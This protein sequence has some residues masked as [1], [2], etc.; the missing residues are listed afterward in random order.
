MRDAI[1]FAAQGGLVDAGGR[2]GD[3]A[4]TRMDLEA[5]L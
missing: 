5:L 2:A 4:A 1:P 3:M